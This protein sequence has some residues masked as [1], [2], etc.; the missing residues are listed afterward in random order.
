MKQL[1]FVERI[2]I[3]PV[4]SLD[5]IWLQEAQIGPGGSLLHD[6]EYAIFD[7]KDKYVNGKKNPLVHQLRLNMDFEAKTI[8]FRHQA[9]TNWH[10]FH[11]Q[12]DK[13]A[14][15]IYLSSFF[16]KQVIL[17]QNTEGGFLDK[18]VKSGMTLLSTASLQTVAGWF[19]N[20]PLEETRQRFRATL[21]LGNVPAFWE[22]RLFTTEGTAIEFT[23]GN[24][25][26]LGMGPRARCVVPTR[27]PQ[28]GK[29]IHAFQKTFAYCREQNLPEGSAL[30]HY[31][32]TYYLSVDCMIPS[33][34]IGK[35]I[36]KGD[37]L[38]LTG[39]KIKVG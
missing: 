24:V 4:K 32:H 16:N 29:D 5:G 15:D 31:G 8:Y 12:H 39:N 35:W 11:L 25:K 34:E 38:K 18:P 14:I 21:E 17:K 28:T 1:P 37:E 27:N 33:S 26:V 3:Y 10:S 20:L 6:R 13:D 9:Q 36:A 23:I 2:C 19:D 30:N 7:E 22:D